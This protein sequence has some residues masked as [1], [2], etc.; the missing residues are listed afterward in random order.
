MKTNFAAGFDAIGGATSSPQ[1]FT[2]S[3]VPESFTFD[4]RK[5]SAADSNEKKEVFLIQWLSFV[6][7][8][9]NKVDA[10][11]VKPAQAEL[12]KTL[13][14]RLTS[15]APKPTR[16]IRQSVARCLALLY[17]KGDGRTLFDTLAAIQAIVA[18][19]K[20]EDPSFRL[21]A[22]TSL[23]ILSEA[24]GGKL[25]SLF[26]ETVSLLSRCL[27]NAKESELALRYESYVALGRSLKG[28]GRGAN[29]QM[30]KDMIKIAKT[31]IA[32]K[33][34]LIRTA[35]VEIFQAV[36]EHTS[37]PVPTKFD[38]YEYLISSAT[39]ALD[40]SNYS[41]RRAVSLFVALI[42]AQSQQPAPKKDKGKKAAGTEAEAAGTAEK[43]ILEV[44]EVLNVLST[45]YIK[46]TSREVRIGI[47]EA[48]ATTLRRLGTKV[49]EDN[50]AQ[51]VK[52]VLALCTNPKLIQTPTEVIF[53][54]QSCDFLLRD[55]I[56]KML[57]ETAQ[58]NAIKELA[59]GWLRRWPAVLGT[60]VAPSDSALVCVLNEVAALF[61]DLGPALA[62]EENIV[63]EPLLKLIAHPSR[64]VNLSL[65]WCLRC[66]SAALPSYLPKLITKLMASIQKDLPNLQGDK[67]EILARFLGY[68][69]VL[70]ALISAAPSR[71]L[72]VSYEAMARIFGLCAQLLRTTSASKDFRAVSALAR[73]AWTLIAS[74]MC[75]G[76]DFVR[77][78]TSQLLL[79]WKN[80]FPKPAPKE[81]GVRSELEWEF[82][83]MSK[84]AAL[85]ALHSFMVHN[86]KEMQASDVAKRITVCLNNTLAFM[87]TLPATYY[88]GP[89]IPPG[90]VNPDTKYFQM[91]N[92]LKKRLFLCFKVL[93][94][95][96]TFELSFSVLLR[97]S[98]DV[99]APDPEKNQDRLLTAMGYAPEKPGAVLQPGSQPSF[100]TSLVQG[101][102]VRI[103]HEAGAEDRGIA[104][105]LNNDTDMQLLEDLLDHVIPGALEND[106]HSL[107][108]QDVTHLH[109]QK[110][111][112]SSTASNTS[113]ELAYK[114]P[115]PAPVG[116]ATIDSA[117]ELFALLLP[118]QNAAVQESLMEQLIIL[119]KSQGTKVPPLR[120]RSVQLNILVAI[121]GSLRYV[122]GKKGSL[123][124][125]KVGVQIR[126]LVEDFLV[127]PDVLFRTLASEALGRLS[128][129][130]GSSVFVNPLVQN[131]VDQIV[132]NRE[133]DVRAGSALALG[134]ILS[135]VG[136]MAAASQL[137]TAVGILHSLASDSHP[138]VHT[139]ALHSLWL[140][141]ESAGLMFGP[142]VNSTVS[143]TV[144]LLTSEA[145]ELSAPAANEQSGNGNADV[146]PAIGRILYALV[147]VIGPEL[148]MST[149]IREHCFALYEQL[150]AEDD[151]FVVVE[152][153]RCIQHFILF[154]P[155]H[156][157]IS[158]LI[159]FLQT[160]L[161]G[162]STTRNYLIR[163][164]AV[165][166][167]YQL[168]QRSPDLV[169]EAAGNNQLE[170]QLFALLDMETDGTVRDE[171]R[172]ILMNLLKH[173]AS[174]RPSRWL[175][176]CKSI[177]SKT[178]GS[179]GEAP[180]AKDIRAM[181]SVAS[182]HGGQGD[183]DDDVF[184]VEHSEEDPPA[185]NE[186]PSAATPTNAS[187]VPA[188]IVLLLLKPRW[189]TQVFALMCLRRLLKEVALTGVKEHFELGLARTAAERA[190][191]RP[192]YLVFKLA[193][194]IRMAFSAATANVK[195][196]RLEGLRLLQ[197]ILEIFSDAP[198]PD[199]DDHA[200]LEQYQ[201]QIGA[202]LTPAFGSDS[203][204]EVLSLAC[205]VS[206]VYIGSGINQELATMSRILRLLT[207]VVERYQGGEAASDAPHA[208]LLVRI[209][210]LT[211]WAKLRIATFS[212]RYLDEV[213]DPNLPSLA[214]LW[215]GVL[216]DYARVKLEPDV[217]SAAAGD[218]SARSSI[219]SYLEAT[220][221][222]V[223]PFYRKSWLTIMEA[224]TSLLDTHLDLFVK[225]MWG[226]SE[227]VELAPRLSKTYFT[228]LGLCVEALATTE[229]AGTLK[230]SGIPGLTAGGNVA[231]STTQSLEDDA[232]LSRVCLEA[233]Q[234]LLKPAALGNDN[235]LD[236]SV[237]LELMTLFDKLV[238]TEDVPVQAMV[239]QI[240]KQIIVEH[241]D[242]I[243]SEESDLR[244]R[245]NSMG[246]SLDGASG[247]ILEQD[248]NGDKSSGPL[249]LKVQRVLKIAFDIFVY[250]V[251][252]LA[253]SP[254]A[255]VTA[256]RDS[257]PETVALILNALDTLTILATT[258]PLLASSKHILIPFSF[259]IFQA[260]LQTE[261]FQEKV[262]PRVLLCIRACLDKLSDAK[263]S[264]LAPVLQATVS[265]LLDS[266]DSEIWH[267]TTEL[268][269]ADPA[270][271]LI[272]KNA[273]MGIV[274]IVT[275]AP[276]STYDDH[277]QT[278]FLKGLGRSLS[279]SEDEIQKTVLQCIKT[280]LASSAS[281][282]PE[283]APIFTSYIRLLLP[284]VAVWV[285]QASAQLRSSETLTASVKSIE[286]GLRLLLVIYGV[287]S[288][289]KK[290]DALAVVV[291]IYISFLSSTEENGIPSFTSSA[292]RELHIA[293]AQML[294]QLASTQP[295][296]FKAAIS[297]LPENDTMALQMGLKTLAEVQQ[298]AAAQTK[299]SST[300]NRGFTSFAAF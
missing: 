230:F 197:D 17:A 233:L 64:S 223:L 156:V 45:L 86:S 247:A 264:T 82:L 217:L 62:G 259:Y 279:H 273:L 272:L 164:A 37:Y 194:L 271:L 203:A 265:S 252:I 42:L 8:D 35:A 115:S 294:F 128:R 47:L 103:A 281:A 235:L 254:T 204:P 118:L 7:R 114:R 30:S 142:Y 149:K 162:E 227:A 155:K 215:V 243:S 218:P 136:G 106:P 120:K 26:P 12:E 113:S 212:H 80:V 51:I 32:D 140:T 38:D 150:K 141:I 165:T 202:A 283:T 99:F 269:A 278:R 87:S 85:A 163:K 46:N 20:P 6:E 222:T 97:A 210:I 132:K 287:V 299:A 174:E 169:L 221:N 31:G 16:P 288:D 111:L 295:Q 126:D 289:T 184:A 263:D 261:K 253:N 280:I 256:N 134:Y 19:K 78:H 224:L 293:S 13:L 29:E 1:C 66:L 176:L 241:S 231:S 188:K 205:Q 282:K 178:G 276:A 266:F 296:H 135:Y 63:I 239:L 39:K 170:E 180:A 71:T 245:L 40:G 9:L 144:K 94:P 154:A 255:A 84:E 48:Y 15:T 201:A 232:N 240:T 10:A 53:M 4:E 14:K 43:N 175:T 131:L 65:A 209:S 28:A 77:V 58:I 237:F 41:V 3:S 284:Q 121:L 112:S 267:L 73:V 214:T 102:V 229:T 196:L 228:L 34:P 177:L 98:L 270:D 187:S 127:S 248:E 60:D 153:I 91:E 151:P 21:A 88:S 36:Y 258:P 101:S 148:Q 158:T 208:D 219:D 249:M 108:L 59:T 200:L 100:T 119:A 275:G 137:K 117:V 206:A 236:A 290:S 76:E 81:S 300:T 191:R 130:V 104:A 251:P 213:V 123:A 54:R 198:D 297:G 192:D 52:N 2:L 105:V 129:V 18:S 83:L 92:F 74:L 186:K 11:T 133:P 260:L 116:T 292:Q 146:Y 286:E 110:S 173:V 79:I 159:P 257:S 179:V 274:L 55:T 25:L 172:D 193:D 69:N 199:F 89:P 242:Y 195:D 246:G 61:I 125:G 44:D 5:L 33:L 122:M 124:S 147:G 226:S 262:A 166:C 185:A 96:S 182:L 56:G 50:Y 109:S 238:Q 250:H 107:Y 145:H 244:L 190:G 268:T 72:Y 298:A 189:R 225:T 161:A 157:D 277:L 138:L 22:I 90:A 68:G 27:K 183:D 291:H 152:A 220:R 216:H 207:G 70:A 160:Q 23:G 95:P 211:S 93:S 75:L 57:G 67:P 139:W 49:V 181:A 234:R 24:H 143:L 171:I 285:L 168:A 167:L